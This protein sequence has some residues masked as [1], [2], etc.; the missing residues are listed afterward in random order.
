[1]ALI[2]LILSKPLFTNVLKIFI[3]PNQVIYH[4]LAHVGL[5]F[6]DSTQIQT[7]EQNQQFLPLVSE[8]HAIRLLVVDHR[9]KE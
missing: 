1:M 9:N 5:T 2:S 7:H 4:M 3:M 8:I 6:S